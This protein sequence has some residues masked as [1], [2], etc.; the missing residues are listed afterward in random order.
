MQYKVYR[1]LRHKEVRFLT[2][3]VLNFPFLDYFE[4]KEFKLETLQLM[5]SVRMRTIINGEGVGF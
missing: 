2:H 1:I 5:K 3:V 4:E